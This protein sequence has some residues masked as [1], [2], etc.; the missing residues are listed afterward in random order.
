MKFLLKSFILCNALVLTSCLT[1]E[2]ALETI[3]RTAL[4][5]F[6]I[7]TV[8]L[9]LVHPFSMAFTPEGDL[10]VTERP[11]R[12][13]IVRNGSLIDDPVEGLPKI[14]AIG[15]GAMP[16]DGYEQAGMRDV[17]L[18]PDFPDALPSVES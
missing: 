5:D 13:R 8:S 4:H 12:L 14:L 17:M 2:V 11:G 7:D 18:H 15:Q 3:T 9:G 1:G 16:Q 6:S 10:L